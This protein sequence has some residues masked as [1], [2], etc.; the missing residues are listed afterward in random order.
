MAEE[1]LDEC[2][3]RSTLLVAVS[4]L[5]ADGNAVEPD[6]ATVRI[7]DER[8]RTVI[9]PATAIPTLATT[10]DIEITSEENRIIKPRA[11]FE[12]RT[13]TVEFDY[14][15]GSGTRHGTA[16]YKYRLLNLYGVVDVPS[17]SVSPSASASPS[18]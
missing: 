13:V 6:A 15:A 5:D 1:C 16:Q 12:I 3:E 2:N 4:F 8:N 17:P 11:K 18:S 9:R 7:D 14:T 10:V